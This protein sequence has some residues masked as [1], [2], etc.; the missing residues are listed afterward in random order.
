M[1]PADHGGLLITA[2]EMLTVKD[3][4]FVLLAR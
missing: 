3:G 4:R 2:F 1:T